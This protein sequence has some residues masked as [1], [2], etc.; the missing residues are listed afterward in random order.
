MEHTKAK[1]T[2]RRSGS[3]AVVGRNPDGTEFIVKCPDE[4]HAKSVAKEL[5]GKVRR[6]KK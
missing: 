5:K 1:S 2:T 6:L 4:A 3:W